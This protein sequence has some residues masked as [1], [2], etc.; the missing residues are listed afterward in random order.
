MTIYDISANEICRRVGKP[1][2]VDRRTDIAVHQLTIDTNA[3]L[4]P[5]FLEFPGVEA[6]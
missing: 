6:T 2:P 4:P 5:V 3:E 1:Q